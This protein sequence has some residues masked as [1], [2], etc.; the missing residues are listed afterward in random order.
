MICHKGF[1]IDCTVDFYVDFMRLLFWDT[2]YYC[3]NTCFKSSL[4]LCSLFS[5][6]S[7]WYHQKSLAP[8][9]EHQK[10]AALFCIQAIEELYVDFNHLS[11]IQWLFLSLWSEPLMVYCRVPEKKVSPREKVQ[12]TC[13]KFNP[14]YWF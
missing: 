4:W 9:I 12:S 11:L 10:A 1:V 14:V 7:F 3:T 13:F 6:T 8:W 5:Y 2:I